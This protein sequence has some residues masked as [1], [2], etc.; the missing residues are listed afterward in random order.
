MSAPKPCFIRRPAQN[1][2]IDTVK[3][4]AADKEDVRRIDLQH[5]LMRMLASALR[6][7]AGNGPFED[8]QK[9]L[10]YTFTGYVAGN[11]RVF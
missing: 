6:R 2:L 4:T 5:F 3:S 10:L 8:F 11:R 9:G 1:G 7:N